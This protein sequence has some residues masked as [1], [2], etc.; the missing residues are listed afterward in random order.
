MF[1]INIRM[2]LSSL[3]GARVRTVLTMLGV[4][5]GVA[6]VVTVVSLG[7]GLKQAVTDEVR[8][9]GND[10]VQVNPGESIVRDDQGNI[11]DFNFGALLGSEPLTEADLKAVKETDGVKIA[12]PIS[13]ISSSITA[14]TNE[15]KGGLII[16]TD[17]DFPQILQ[18]SVAEGAYFTQE[19][20]DEPFA[21]VGQKIANQLFGEG[22]PLGRKLLIRGQEFT[23]IGVMQEYESL[24]AGGFGGPDYNQ[25]IYVPLS[26]GIKLNQGL[27]LIQ[28]IDFRVTDVTDIDPTISRVGDALAANRGGERNFSISKP[29]EFLDI[30]N[31][32]LNQ[33]TLAVSAIAFISVVVGGIG[34]MNIMFVTVSE[35]TREIGIRKAIGATPRQIRSQFLIEA[36]VLSLLGALLGLGLA[37]IGIL[38]VS[39]LTEFTPK[40]TA[41]V[42]I[43][44]VVG[45]LLVGVISGIVPAVKAARKDPIESLRHD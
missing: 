35:R 9:F 2:A 24:F 1:G 5:I 16:A 28:E 41:L 45:S 12:V 43:L 30:T 25:V 33:V 29:E 38:L 21:V 31:E 23:V 6:S 37:L 42:M 44:S 13:I 32:L 7:E 39:T 22:T 8:R 36:M 15:V 20:N 26:Q 17:P 18:Q 4:I 3:K 19:Q 34:I 11:T 10:I 40:L 27:T 14:G